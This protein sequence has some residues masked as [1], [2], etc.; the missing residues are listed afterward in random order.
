MEIDL[1]PDT[2][3]ITALGYLCL[4]SRLKRLGERMQ[5]G[6][7][8]VLA[9]LGHRVQPAQLPILMALRN[10]GAMTIGLLGQRVGISQPG[11][12]RAIAAL[13]S[14]GLVC[15]S[16]TGRD[17]RQRS[18]ELS[19][20]GTAMMDG[21]RARLFPAVDQAV[22][23]LCAEVNAAFLDDIGG[24]ENGLGREPLEQR[25]KRHLAASAHD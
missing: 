11:V 7:V 10:E 4:G 20:V 13:E 12:S 24:I 6:V 2:D 3:I 15:A 9:E 17:R 22:G 14:E 1:S 16:P 25:I 5:S 21:L 8:P 18:V 19:A 23:Q